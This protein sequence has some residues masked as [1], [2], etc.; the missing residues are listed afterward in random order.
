MSSFLLI[1]FFFFFCIN[2]YSVNVNKQKSMPSTANETVVLKSSTALENR[3]SFANCQHFIVGSVNIISYSC[4]SLNVFWQMNRHSFCYEKNDLLLKQIRWT[5]STFS[6]V[7]F[8]CQWFHF[9]SNDLFSTVHCF[10]ISSIGMKC[11]TELIMN[12]ELMTRGIDWNLG[13]GEK[14]LKSTAFYINNVLINIIDVSIHN[15]RKEKRKL[16]VEQN[17]SQ[18]KMKQDTLTHTHTA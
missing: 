4:A 13:V 14:R 12:F 10:S 6:V 15:R 17:V 7:L 9:I 5:S 2:I 11:M 16:P 3:E 18:M 1:T 8:K